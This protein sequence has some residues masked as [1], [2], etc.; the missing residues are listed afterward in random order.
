MYTLR[1]IL[2]LMPVALAAVPA[3]AADWISPQPLRPRQF[4]R[5]VNFGDS[6]SDVG[7]LRIFAPAYVQASFPSPPYYD[8]RFSNGP[9]WVEVL[10]GHLGVPVPTASLVGGPNATNYAYGGAQVVGHASLNVPSLQDQVALFLGKDN[11]GATDLFTFR[12]G[13]NDFSFGQTDPGVPTG[14]IRDL[15]V[16]LAERGARHFLWAE[17][18]PIGSSPRRRGTPDE[19]RFNNL[20]T[21][22]N[23]LL[24]SHV[25]AL[26]VQLG[27]SVA[28]YEFDTYG[29]YEQLF[30]RPGD[31]GLT[32]VTEPALS[33]LGPPPVIVADPDQYLYWDRTGHSTRVF[34]RMQAEAMLPEPSPADFDHDF[35]VDV[36]DLKI[37][38]ACVS[39]PAVSYD[40]AQLPPACTV[41][42]AGQS[43]PPDFDKDADVDQDDFGIFQRCWSGANNP[44]DPNCTA[45]G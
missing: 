26:R 40:A 32:N 27:P 20:A 18:A 31:F 17:L 39:G 8:G 10:A 16:S 22:F 2:F 13:G 37:F 36:D 33:S 9:V 30:A 4:G 28:I 7:N 21:Q 23:A 29:L 34:H 12:G 1:G 5:I 14:A 19:Q 35:D 44:A 24:A 3:I 42:P 38:L 6:G 45:G 25:A 15:I 41:T 43:I 11:P